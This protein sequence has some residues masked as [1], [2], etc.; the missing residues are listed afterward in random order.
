MIQEGQTATG[1][2]GHK[3]MMRGGQLI[4]LTTNQPL[5]Q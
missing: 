1:P 4:D 2:N 3:I 5:A